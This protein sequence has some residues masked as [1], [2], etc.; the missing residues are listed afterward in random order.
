MSGKALNAVLW[1]KLTPTQKLVLTV[2]ALY[3]D[4]S[5]SCTLSVPTLAKA[6][7]LCEGTISKALTQLNESG[8]IVRQ[9]RPCAPS[10]FWIDVAFAAKKA[11]RRRPT[12]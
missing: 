8:Y 4:D 2:L 1:L 10:M 5:A 12:N 11:A 3:A 7:S 6:T 9:F